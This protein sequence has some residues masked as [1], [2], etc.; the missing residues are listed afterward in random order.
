M[1]STAVLVVFLFVLALMLIV[2][3]PKSTE[4]EGFA[5][6]SVDALRMPACAERSASAQR[7]LAD[8]AHLPESDEAA[9]ELRLLLSKLCCMEADLVTPASGAPRT[10]QLQFRTSHD[11]EPPSTIVG[12]CRRNAVRQR[13]IDLIIEKFEKRG[14]ALVQSRCSGSELVAEFDKVVN[15]TRLT[16]NSF[17]L[18]N[19]PSMDKPLGSRDLGYWAP[20]DTDLEQ[21]QGIS[22]SIK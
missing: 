20:E 18:G 2:Y 17:C 6:A 22:A 7:I 4:T 16:M 9:A 11:M 13:D 21:Y 14:R 12:R 10:L 3:K 19:Q 15:Q 1:Y 8:I 5:V